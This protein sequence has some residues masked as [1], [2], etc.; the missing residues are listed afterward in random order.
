MSKLQELQ[1]EIEV[2]KRRLR[3]LE[4]E[5]DEIKVSKTLEHS[6]RYDLLHEK[7]K[8]KIL[9]RERIKDL[10]REINEVQGKY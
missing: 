9:I 7:T 2:E 8:E 5:Y 10:K 4:E 6:R 1:L 3:M